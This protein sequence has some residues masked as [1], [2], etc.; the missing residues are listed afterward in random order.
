[1]YNKSPA[2]SQQPFW[3]I[4]VP[5][6]ASTAIMLTS[7]LSMKANVMIVL[8][9]TKCEPHSVIALYTDLCHNNK[10]LFGKP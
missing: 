6:L 3:P 8:P 2:K 4:M 1:M 7:R 10:Y 9:C 5:I